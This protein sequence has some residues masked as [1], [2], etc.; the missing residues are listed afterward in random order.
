MLIPF[1]TWTVWNTLNAWRLPID[2]APMKYVAPDSPHQTREWRKRILH[3]HAHTNHTPYTNAIKTERDT[4][5]DDG[6]WV[7]VCVFVCNCAFALSTHSWI[8]N[9]RSCEIHPY[10]GEYS[11]RR[12]LHSRSFAAFD[13]VCSF[14]SL[15]QLI[16][17]HTHT[18]Q[19]KHVK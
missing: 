8:I 13:S 7:F 10:A 12:A 3:T 1:N 14:L 11:E 15:T 4:I 16:K 9:K 19:H 6:V 5:D 18:H 2:Y 17:P